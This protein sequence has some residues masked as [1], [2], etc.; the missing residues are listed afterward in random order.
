MKSRILNTTTVFWLKIDVLFEQWDCVEF[1]D[2]PLPFCF[3]V[4]IEGAW[5]SF[6]PH[7][8]VQLQF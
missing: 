2:E 7:F 8:A 6:A 3:D 5:A 1:D 4:K